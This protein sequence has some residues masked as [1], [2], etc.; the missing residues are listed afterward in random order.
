ME[1]QPMHDGETSSIREA[2]DLLAL[3][4]GEAVFLISPETG[5]VLTFAGLRE[6]SLAI[7]ARLHEAGL[8]ARRKGC[9]SDG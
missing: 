7:S 9:L 6:Q 1:A 3:R 8:Q 2:V 5:R 4:Q